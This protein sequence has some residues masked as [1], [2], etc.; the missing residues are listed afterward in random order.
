MKSRIEG[1]LNNPAGFGASSRDR[2][3]QAARTLFAGKGYEHTSTVAIARAAGSSES[4]LMKHFGSK[5]GLLEAIFDEAWGRINWNLRRAI[6]DLDSPVEKFST[7]GSLVMQSLDRDA[8]VKLLMLLEGR[9]VRKAGQMIALSQS[10]L[11]FVRLL[12]DVLSQMRAAGQ[13]R[14]DLDPQAVRSALMGMLEG[15]MRDQLMARRIGYPARYGTEEIRAA[16]NTA[17]ASFIVPGAQ[18]AS[19][20]LVGATQLNRSRPSHRKS[21]ARSV[22]RSTPSS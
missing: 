22:L 20:P 18:L 6:Q 14:P 1:P 15:L 17:A 16:F 21:R 4:Q 9:R 5:E 10:Y 3:L 7:L 8:E 11:E 12:D 13:L 19:G 2:I